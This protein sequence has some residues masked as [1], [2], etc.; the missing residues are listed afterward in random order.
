MSELRIVRPGEGRPWW[1]QGT[2]VRWLAS[3]DDTDGRFALQEVAVKPGHGPGAHIQTREDECFYLLAG[4]PLEVRA[5]NRTARLEGGG[6]IQIGR[7]TAHDF[8]NAGEADAKLLVA[9]FPA[10]FEQFQFEAGEEPED[11]D[12]PRKANDADRRRLA[13][14]A[15][16]FGI[17]LD[18]G[19]E[20]FGREP[21]IHIVQ[22]GGGPSANLS[23]N[24][25]TALATSDQTQ[26]GY[27]LYDVGVA[28]G[29]PPYEI[30]DV[31]LAVYAVRG[32]L[33]LEVDG[34][35]HA[36]PPGTLV[37]L[38]PG[39]AYRLHGSNEQ[40]GRALIW[41]APAHDLMAR[42]AAP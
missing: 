2:I 30:H 3:G 8:R 37:Q 36:L 40:P 1:W 38:P 31:P 7:G 19:E 41:T 26:G 5:G 15:P 14:L 12:E 28:P 13:E 11:P 25:W 29:E 23:G 6:F 35:Y 27:A 39:V 9:C 17:E 10:G 18:P 21:A 16:K 32:T 33:G 22:P 42:V 34:T 24:A 20:A 4:G